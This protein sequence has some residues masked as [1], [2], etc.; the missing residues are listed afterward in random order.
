MTRYQVGKDDVCLQ[1]CGRESTRKSSLKWFTKAYA[2][3]ML[4]EYRINWCLSKPLP[5]PRNRNADVASADAIDSL[6]FVRMRLWS[7]RNINLIAECREPQDWAITFPIN[8]HQLL[9]PISCID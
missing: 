4:M 6:A 5:A 8:A 1:I 9:K 2:F 7:L 3:C